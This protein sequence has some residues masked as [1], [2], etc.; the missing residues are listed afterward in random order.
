MAHTNR[1]RSRPTRSWLTQLRFPP[2]QAGGSCVLSSLVTQAVRDTVS[3]AQTIV[4]LDVASSDGGS[5]SS[6]T[7]KSFTFSSLYTKAVSECEQVRTAGCVST[8]IDWVV[9]KT[10]DRTACQ[11]LGNLCVLVMYDENHV[12][13]KRFF[14]LEATISSS[15]R[16]GNFPGWCG[17]ELSQT[18]VQLC[19]WSGRR[20]SLGCALQTLRC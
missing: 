3:A 1:C 12:V 7:V 2:W 15:V 18:N 5:T 11:V 10:R 13:C 17:A 4:Y 14:A 19:A 16:G 8:H 9:R 6:I 20:D